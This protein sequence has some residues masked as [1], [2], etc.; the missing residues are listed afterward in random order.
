MMIPGVADAVVIGV[1]GDGEQAVRKMRSKEKEESLRML[2]RKIMLWAIYCAQLFDS[3]LQLFEGSHP[4]DGVDEICQGGASLSQGADRRPDRIFSR[5]AARR[6]CVGSMKRKVGLIQFAEQV[7]IF[8]EELPALLHIS[9][10]FCD[11]SLSQ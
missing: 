7:S 1:A 5:R 10:S 2:N 4:R 8:P 11:L 6:I 9:L 3:L